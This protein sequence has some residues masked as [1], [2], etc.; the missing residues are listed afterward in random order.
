VDHEQTQEGGDKRVGHDHEHAAGEPHVDAADQQSAQGQS[1]EVGAAQAPQV[2]GSRRRGGVM[3]ADAARQVLQDAFG[4]YRTISAGSVR[5]LD[6]AAFQTAYDAVYGTTRFAWATW[7][8]PTHGNLNGFAHNGVNYINAAT[9]NAGTVA[10]EML[11][12]NIASDWRTFVGNQFDEGATDVLKQ[13]ALRAAGITAPNSYP[14]QMAV[15]EAFLASGVTRE[16][17][18][19]AYLRG[20]AATIVGRHVDNTCVGTWAQVKEASQAQNWAQA[21]ARLARRPAGSTR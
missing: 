7:V 14:N 8:V 1:G 21:R 9:A 16:Q 20:G 12:N 3:Q 19:T 4:S 10:H 13:H 17:L 6:Q 15:V 2:E 18:F 11:H 5:V